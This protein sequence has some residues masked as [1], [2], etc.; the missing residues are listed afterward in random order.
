MILIGLM[1][2]S[3]LAVATIVGRHIVTLERATSQK[4]HLDQVSLLINQIAFESF[5][6]H[7]LMAQMLDDGPKA[8][9]NDGPVDRVL[10][11]RI[12]KITQNIGRLKALSAA[13]GAARVAPLRDTEQPLQEIERLLVRLQ[14]VDHDALTLK[15]E[16]GVSEDDGIQ[17]RLRTYIHRLEMRLASKNDHK[18]MVN[19]LQLRRREKDFMLRGH[20]ESLQLFQQ[21]LQVMQTTMDAF[22]EL[23]AVDIT[24]I[25]QT[26][27][28]YRQEAERLQQRMPLFEKYQRELLE[29]NNAILANNTVLTYKNQQLMLYN[30]S[31]QENTLNQTGLSL[32]L[33]LSVTFLLLGWVTY[34]FFQSLLIPI[35]LL[36]Q[37]A[38]QISRGQY[39]LKIALYGTDEIGA[40]SSCLQEM[41]QSLLHQQNILANQ[42][43]IRTE[44]LEITNAVLHDTIKQLNDTHQE[45]LHSEKMASLGRLVAGFS[46]EI[47]TPIGIAITTISNIPELI[48]DLHQ[49][50]SQDEV[51]EDELG[52]LLTQL[53][54]T[55]ELGLSSLKKAA[56]LVTRFKRTSAD[57]ASEEARSFNINEMM[58]DILATLHTAFKKSPIV[59]ELRCPMDI[60]LHSQPGLIGQVMTNLLMNSLK[61]GFDNGTREGRIVIEVQMLDGMPKKLAIRYQDNGAGIHPDHL[62][63]IFDPFFTTARERGGSGLG[64]TICYN[65]VTT[66]LRGE[67]VCQSEWGEGVVFEIRLPAAQGS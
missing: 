2:V 35:Q 32:L 29:I 53:T 66:Q 28:S 50:L 26:F 5:G 33:S 59:I 8:S 45:L 61:H 14:Q 9:D 38:N 17:G 15:Q 63:N 43:Q 6:F 51:D 62:K 22:P 10:D 23:G 52:A 55:A 21:A 65:I 58:Q 41:K 1:A 44:H 46:H 67:I 37:Y 56:N 40:L 7:L 57:Q 24:H 13:D 18:A 31:D 25:K 19:L 48:R 11:D 4:K 34:L 12:V 20:P 39:D 30:T 64:L 3:Y 16:I 60:T 49:M 36:S 27:A 42:V 54:Q 47:N